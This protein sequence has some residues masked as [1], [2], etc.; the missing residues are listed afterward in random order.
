MRINLGCGLIYKKGFVNVDGF[1]ST[2]ADLLMSAFNLDLDDN[3]AD[4]IE[5]SQVLEHLGA[6]KSLYALSECFRVL[7]PEGTLLIESKK[8]EKGDQ[9]LVVISDDGNGIE[10]RDIKRIF[11][12]L[13]TTK[14]AGNGIGLSIA[15]RV[16]DKSNGEIV[17][18][19]KK[20]IG[21]EFKVYFPF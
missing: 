4:V 14:S 17:V 21:T 11:D 16:F 3:I 13:Y 9:I 2:V 12:P 15:K 7:K 1:D 20:N 5:S 10:E 6:V 8:I 19:S 18:H